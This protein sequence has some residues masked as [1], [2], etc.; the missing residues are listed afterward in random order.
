[1]L[2]LSPL[3]AFGFAKGKASVGT[4]RRSPSLQSTPVHSCGRHQKIC[5]TDNIH[6]HI[7]GAKA[8]R[9][10]EHYTLG[11]LQVVQYEWGV[12]RRWQ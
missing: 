8:K 6:I 11:M 1:V 12:E 2:S 9:E 7:Y 5:D 3:L 4:T 10:E